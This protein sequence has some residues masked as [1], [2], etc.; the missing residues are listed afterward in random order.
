MSLFVVTGSID[1]R[2]SVC[3]NSGKSQRWDAAWIALKEISL[4]FSSLQLWSFPCCVGQGWIKQKGKL[5]KVAVPQASQ[6]VRKASKSLTPH[7]CY[8]TNPDTRV[9]CWKKSK[10]LSLSSVSEEQLQER[11]RRRTVLYILLRNHFHISIPSYKVAHQYH[12]IPLSSL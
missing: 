3:H 2:Y 12:G 10:V 11:R 1:N 8:L 6:G 7:K 4:C 9:G 5:D